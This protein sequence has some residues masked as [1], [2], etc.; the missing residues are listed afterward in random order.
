MDDET[1]WH[2]YFSLSKEYLPDI[3]FLWNDGDYLPP[4]S[5]MEQQE[6]RFM[7][8]DALGSQLRSLSHTISSAASAAAANSGPAG[9]QLAAILKRDTGVDVSSNGDTT[10]SDVAVGNTSSE[11]PKSLLGVDPDL[12]AYLQDVEEEEEDDDDGLDEES[13]E[14]ISSV[15]DELKIER[16]NKSNASH[17]TDQYGSTTATQVGDGHAAAGTATTLSNTNEGA[18]NDIDLDKYLN[19]L[20]KEI[21]DGG[22]DGFDGLLDDDVDDG[23]VDAVLRQLQIDVGDDDGDRGETS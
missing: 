7:S 20:S 2:V 1:F 18:D 16:E 19:E 5:S 3:T 14:V 9:V 13:K 22:S 17:D 21:D 15:M 10:Q 23:D 11:L 12:E 4:V 6:D 8:F